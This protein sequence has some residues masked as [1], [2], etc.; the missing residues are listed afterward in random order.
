V[1]DEALALLVGLGAADI[2]HPGGRL[3]DHLVRTHDLLEEWGEAPAVRL[4]GL[5]H[6]AYGTD[7]FPTPLLDLGDRQRLRAVIGEDAE[8]LVYDYGACDRRATYARLGERPLRLTDRFTGTTHAFGHGDGD[9]DGDAAAFAALT[10][11]N[12][13]DVLRHGSLAPAAI[14]AITALLPAVAGHAPAAA[15]R[16]VDELVAHG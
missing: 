5:C 12:E 8:H 13:L 9:G 16:A 15:A 14:G 6:A 11:A 10:I 3:L 4:A 2:P 1:T 7:G